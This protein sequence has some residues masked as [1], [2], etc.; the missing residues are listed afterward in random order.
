LICFY[1][2]ICRNIHIVS[3]CCF[4]SNFP[5]KSFDHT[6][7]LQRLS[8]QFI[9]L[10]IWDLSSIFQHKSTEI[11]AFIL[12]TAAFLDTFKQHSIQM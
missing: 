11:N 12:F 4:S 2:W 1:Y 5:V 9:C 3:Y 6:S 10:Y 7:N 8:L